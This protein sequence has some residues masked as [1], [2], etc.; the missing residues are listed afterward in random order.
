MLQ[1][2][3]LFIKK[4]KKITKIRTYR[5]MI[6]NVTWYDFAIFNVTLVH[7][8]MKIIQIYNFEHP[9]NVFFG[10]LNANLK[11]NNLKTIN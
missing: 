1:F 5:K 2:L 8:N 7:D 10:K 9:N 4:E 3:R 11:Y 6:Y